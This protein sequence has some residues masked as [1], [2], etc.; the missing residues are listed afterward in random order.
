M[1]RRIT[2]VTAD[3]SS[4]REAL[5]WP[6]VLTT[7][8]L[9][10]ALGNVLAKAVYG[11]GVTQV[12]LFVVR[13]IAVYL[14]NAAL[15]AWRAGVATAW[16]VATLRVGSRRIVGLCILRSA[17]GFLGISLLNVAYQLITLA[18][19]FALT[20]CVLT[21]ATVV[22]ARLCI[23]GSERLT[24][25]SLAGG[26]TA[27]V[28]MV[29]ITQ[30][31]ALFGSSMPPGAAGIVLSVAAGLAFTAFTILSRVLGRA[32]R[33]GG[34]GAASPAMLVSYYMVVIEVGT[35][36]IALLHAMVGEPGRENGA[37]VTVPSHLGASSY[38]GLRPP[39][40]APPP[41]SPPPAPATWSWAKLEAPSGAWNWFL[42]SLYCLAILVGQL[43]LAAGYAKIAAGRAAIIALTEIGFSWLLDVTILR[44]PT[45]L[46]AASGTLIVFLGCS[47]AATGQAASTNRSQ[48]PPDDAERATKG[49]PTQP[50]AHQNAQSQEVDLAD[51]VEGSVAAVA[52]ADSTKEPSAAPADSELT[53]VAQ[54]SAAPPVAATAPPSSIAEQ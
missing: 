23:G 50:L 2:I 47:I 11:N 3:R 51:W 26:L 54:A 44:E 33:G 36:C 49:A 45:N 28:G 5:L 15:E 29:L 7:G 52:Q 35:L 53:R 37:L 40:A 13:G 16:R 43:C 46:L 6:A 39:Y 12:S 17:A 14:L 4:R 8:A 41:P 32:A 19:A 21:L 48:P 27:V 9:F 38:G 20:L 25:R 1:C 10:F 42:I 24:L 31:E 18:D 34:A 30:P 22:A